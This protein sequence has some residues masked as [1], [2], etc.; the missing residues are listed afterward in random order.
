MSLF[1]RSWT[2]CPH[3]GWGLRT[4][5]SGRY[6]KSYR[7][8][9]DQL[10]QSSIPSGTGKKD[11]KKG[12]RKR[13]SKPPREVS[14]FGDRIEPG[15]S[16]EKEDDTPYDVVFIKDTKATTCYGCKGNVRNTAAEPPPPAPYDIF[17]FIYICIFMVSYSS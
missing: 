9:L 1:H 10:V 3:I 11:H 5:K 16:I 13:T 12:K 6:T 8:S 4:W 7:V 15:P 2:L 14:T 17:I